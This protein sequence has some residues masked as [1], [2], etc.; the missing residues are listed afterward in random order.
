MDGFG[1]LAPACALQPVGELELPSLMPGV[2]MIRWCVLMR[3]FWWVPGNL[4]AGLWSQGLSAGVSCWTGGEAWAA[5]NQGTVRPLGHDGDVA[6]LRL[7]HGGY[8][9]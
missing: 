7:K 8:F 5:D 6:F 3:L 4:P 2:G 9:L 1:R